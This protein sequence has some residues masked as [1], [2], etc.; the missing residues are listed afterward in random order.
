MKHKKERVVSV[1]S[2]VS[3]TFGDLWND[4]DGG[5]GYPIIQFYQEFFFLFVP[6]LLFHLCLKNKYFLE[7][8][9]FKLLIFF[10]VYFSN[11]PQHHF[12][13]DSCIYVFP[14]KRLFWL[15]K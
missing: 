5:G 8:L 4:D 10:H 15:M 11:H 13:E 1:L 14:N 3:A 9:K 2:S 6:L 7:L 12:F